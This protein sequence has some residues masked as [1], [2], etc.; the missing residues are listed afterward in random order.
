MNNKPLVFLDMDGVCTQWIPACLVAHKSD[1]VVADITGWMQDHLGVSSEEMWAPIDAL[2][3][4]WW[5]DL[6]P[7]PWF[8]RLWDE[9]NRVASEVV[10]VTDP[11]TSKHGVPGKKM[12]INKHVGG[13]EQSILHWHGKMS[14]ASRSAIFT[15][16]KSTL[17]CIPN[18]VLID[19]MTHH[20]DA[21]R[22]AGGKA[23]LFPQFWNEA[24]APE[25]VDVVD[26]VVSEITRP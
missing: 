17:A 5:R 23:V 11:A 10:F 20:V 7:W 22:A 4:E 25:G 15:S 24:Q 8:S 19:D 12:W 16:R 9:L 26:F 6:E 13:D 18:S 3:P 1:L 2:G 14:A 21:F